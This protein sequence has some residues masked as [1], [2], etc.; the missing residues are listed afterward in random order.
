MEDFL[1]FHADLEF[2]E[3][4]SLYKTR[5]YTLQGSFEVGN[6]GSIVGKEEVY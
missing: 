2:E 6:E 4:D 5:C 1:L 3:M